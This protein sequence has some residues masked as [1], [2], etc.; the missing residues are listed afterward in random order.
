MKDVPIALKELLIGRP[1]RALAFSGGTDSSYLLWACI[2]LGMD[3]RPYFVK[4]AFQT[5]SELERAN[6]F[7]ERLGVVLTVIEVDILADEEIISNPEDR[8]Y[9]CKRK[10]FSMIRDVSS[11]DGC[12][13]IMD[14]TNASDDPAI[15]PGMRALAE[16]GVLSP[17][18]ECGL[19][20][21][22]IRELS[23][24]AGLDNWD[25]PSDSCLATRILTGY[26]ITADDLRKVESAE[27]EIRELGFR[28]FRV[29]SF[30]SRCRLDTVPTQS[31]LS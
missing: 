6:D 11:K 19:T 4:G 1:K 18:K 16:L 21:P 26:R 15:R 9:L 20:K 28:D 10:V 5:D 8:C 22:E 24:L 30:D 3:V 27:R 12:F 31:E 25:V 2:E 17:L 29:R 13:D 14:A 7:C 23:R